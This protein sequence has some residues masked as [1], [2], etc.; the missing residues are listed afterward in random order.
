MFRSITTVLIASA[1]ATAPALA[2]PS[3]K[4]FAGSYDGITE[5]RNDTGDTI[6]YSPVRFKIRRD[7]TITGTAKNHDTGKL[8]KVRGSIGKVTSL[9]GIRFT[10]KA[11][12]TF[13]DGTKW[14]AEVEA[15]K[16]VSAKGIRGKARRG[17]YSGALS[18]TNLS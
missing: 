16:G 8:L 7:G 5:I 2:A 9:F 6:F 3:K 4:I 10:G 1:F 18:L 13:S 12:G 14:N 11:A 15:M 17:G